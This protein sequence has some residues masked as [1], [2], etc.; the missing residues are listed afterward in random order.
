M[1]KYTTS[2]LEAGRGGDLETVIDAMKNEAQMNFKCG[3]LIL[4][5]FE[6]KNYVDLKFDFVTPR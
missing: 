4:H 5:K 6:L 1:Q 2:K 3:S